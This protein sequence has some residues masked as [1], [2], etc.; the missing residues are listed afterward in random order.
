MK[1][2]SLTTL[3]DAIRTPGAERRRSRRR[4]RAAAMVPAT[5]VPWRTGRRPPDARASGPVRPF[6]MQL[7][8]SRASKFGARSGWVVV[9]SAVVDA[10]QHAPASRSVTLC[11]WSA[12]I[13]TMSH[14]SLS[15]GSSTGV[16]VVSS[17]ELR[18][19]CPLADN[20]RPGGAD[21]LHLA[22]PS[23]PARTSTLEFAF[24]DC[25]TTT[26]ETARTTESTVPAGVR[27]RVLDLPDVFPGEAFV[28]MT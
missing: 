10:D 4:F 15:R 23:R 6:L 28:L 18:S 27:H 8:E 1:P 9:D 16:A 11:A 17:T 25:A 2:S 24:V 3:T 20:R 26:P 5:C 12:L 22:P 19:A 13:W 14:C 7:T 21:R